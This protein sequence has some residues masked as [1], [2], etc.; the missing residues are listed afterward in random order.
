MDSV[1]GYYSGCL[2]R[3]IRLSIL[4]G[5]WFIMGMPSLRRTGISMGFSARQPDPTSYP[6]H[7]YYDLT[8]T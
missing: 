5:M 8:A 1:N 6:Y 4:F 7:F 3:I 2:T